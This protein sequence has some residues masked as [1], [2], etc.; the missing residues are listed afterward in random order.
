MVDGA[1]TAYALAAL[2][3]RGVLFIDPGVEVYQGMV[4][5]E[6][7]TGAELDVNPCKSKA[8]TNFR[9]VNAD[10]AIRLQ[11]PRVL[12]LEEAIGDLAPDELLEVTPGALRLR[13]VELDPGRRRADLKRAAKEAS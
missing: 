4:I 2:E 10:E 5:G 7:S 6:S 1:A 8:L 11:P 3:A 9:T 12:S 13:K